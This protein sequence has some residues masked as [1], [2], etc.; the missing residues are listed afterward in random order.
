MTQ[1]RFML[2]QFI[3]PGCWVGQQW[4]IKVLQYQPDPNWQKAVPGTAFW[5][6]TGTVWVSGWVSGWYCK[7]DACRNLSP[8]THR[9]CWCGLFFNTS[10][11]SSGELFWWKVKPSTICQFSVHVRHF[12]N[13][14]KNQWTNFK[15]TSHKLSL[16]K[17]D[18][19]LFQSRHHRRLMTGFCFEEP[20]TQKHLKTSSYNE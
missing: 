18:S 4:V 10:A 14:I 17:A 8:R 6:C 20:W 9:N 13:I 12:G 3:V 16:S 11:G 1:S 15:R 7:N 2:V 19:Q 5:D